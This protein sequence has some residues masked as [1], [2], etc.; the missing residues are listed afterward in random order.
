MDQN[1]RMRID[2][3]LR[4]AHAATPLHVFKAPPCPVHAHGEIDDSGEIIDR[5][6]Y[7]DLIGALAP[8]TRISALPN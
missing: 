2:R 3:G 1:V 7:H 8:G 5:K 4:M 6:T